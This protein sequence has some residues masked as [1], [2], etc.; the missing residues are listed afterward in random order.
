[1]SLFVLR[2]ASCRFYSTPIF[3]SPE[4]KKYLDLNKN[5]NTKKNL[6]KKTNSKDI[7]Y[8]SYSSYKHM[9]SGLPI[10]NIYKK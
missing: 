9:Y 2:R 6:I 8:E 7:S 3:N 1:M 5:K 4:G 10:K